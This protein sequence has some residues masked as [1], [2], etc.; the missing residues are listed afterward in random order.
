M[1]SACYIREGRFRATAAIKIL[2]KLAAG[3]AGIAR[4]LIPYRPLYT[5]SGT[6]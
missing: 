4:F 1:F 2:A 3:T 6:L 5:S